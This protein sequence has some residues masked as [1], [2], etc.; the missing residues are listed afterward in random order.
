MIKSKDISVVIQG[1]VDTTYTPKCVE[2]V[3]R[4]L[5]EAEIIV[6]TWSG[7][8]ISNLQ[9]DKSVFSEDPGCGYD[10][11]DNRRAL[12]VNR[13]VV[14]SVAGVRL[15]SRSYVLKC[16]SDSELVNVKFLKYW[17]K[18]G[19]RDKFYSLAQHKILIPSPYTMK[20]LGDGQ[21]NKIFTPFHV[22]DW[23]CF[24]LRSDIQEF[25]DIPLI[26]NI[27]EFARF[28]EKRDI[29]IPASCRWWMDDWFR[30]MAAEQYIGLC[31]AKK[32]YLNIDMKNF[33]EWENFDERFAE[34][35]MLNNFIVLDP[36][37]FGIII[38]KFRNFSKHIYILG[39]EL[40]SGMYRNYIY[41]R[42]Y[43]RYFKIYKRNMCD[44]MEIKRGIFLVAKLIV[45]KKNSFDNLIRR[46]FNDVKKI[47]PKTF[48]CVIIKQF[49][50]AL[51]GYLIYK[52]IQKKYLICD[53]LYICPYRGTGDSFIIGNYFYIK[54]LNMNN[55]VFIVQRNVNKKILSYFYIK[56]VEILSNKDIVD[57]IIYQKISQTNQ[58]KTLHYDAPLEHR[59][60]G[61]NI[62]G[63]K[64]I[65]FADFYDYIVFDQD[66]PVL[67]S[68]IPL[69]SKGLSCSL[70]AQIDM[71]NTVLLAPYSDSIP[72]LKEEEWVFLVKELKKKGYL[73]FTNCANDYEAAISG[74]MPINVKFEELAYFLDMC[75]LLISVRSGLCDIACMSNCRKIIF[76]PEYIFYNYGKYIDFFTLNIPERNLYA[77]E[78]EYNMHDN[79]SMLKSILA[80]IEEV[81]R[82]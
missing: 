45:R 73:V 9:V 67:Y 23:Y 66:T 32:K 79:Y 34:A 28:F 29:F 8:D 52:K 62:A 25:V 18:Y 50:H 2:S 71:G 39:G 36:Y 27:Q 10:G 70:I 44:L 38:N 41:V 42:D 16:R 69:L 1:P 47:I 49:L 58:I 4:L 68:R 11:R 20:Y 60:I 13:W 7:S 3:K 65:N 53:Q 22:S 81:N 55:S 46:I 19:K 80:T 56:K 33:L 75:G 77:E 5:P 51:H 6:S 26:T 15:A 82:E 64:K 78:Y 76:Y 24:G 63:Y 21:K 59:S 48:G 74:T 35:F 54:G 12:N 14:S 37:Q 40:W 43:C 31:Y 17:D 30:K 72:S 61:Y 57:L